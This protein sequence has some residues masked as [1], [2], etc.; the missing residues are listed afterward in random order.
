MCFV[1]LCCTQVPVGLP[2]GNELGM[3][4]HSDF[5][6]AATVGGLSH[7]LSQVWG[8]EP[9]NADTLAEQACHPVHV[10]CGSGILLLLLLRQM[11]LPLL[12][13]VF[14]WDLLGHSWQAIR[15]CGVRN[16]LAY[17]ALLLL[18]LW[19]DQPLLLVDVQWGWIG[20]TGLC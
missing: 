18:S 17:L 3:Q 12:R 4:P 11:G 6:D 14:A 19:A 10:S 2:S 1:L 16:G 9:D 5:A 15:R 7:L 20:L 13:W 8:R